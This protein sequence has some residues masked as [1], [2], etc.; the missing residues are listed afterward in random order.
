MVTKKTQV[1]SSNLFVLAQEISDLFLRISNV[2]RRFPVFLSLDLPQL[3]D[4]QGQ[5]LKFCDTK[6]FNRTPEW[7]VRFTILLGYHHIPFSSL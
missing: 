7:T 5:M 1:V 3:L 4:T 2:L 6:R